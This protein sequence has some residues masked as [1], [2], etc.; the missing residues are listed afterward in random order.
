[1]ISCPLCVL[2]Q[3]AIFW[4]HT[5]ESENAFAEVARIQKLN[6]SSD[7]DIDQE[8]KACIELEPALKN[9]ET[10]WK[11]KARIKWHCEG[12]RCS[13]YFHQVTKLRHV[14]KGIKALKHDDT[15]LTNRDQ[16]EQK[17]IAYFTYHYSV[18]NN[19]TSNSLVQDRI[20][21]LVTAKD[22]SFLTTI[23]S[24]EEI[25]LV[26]FSSNADNAPGPNGF[27]CCFL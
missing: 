6:S 4:E 21:Y 9:Q 13:T 2:T 23:P 15:I 19:Y 1:M 11:D 5:L 7:P 27:G 26:V 3:W 8:T 12:D 25:R 16:I 18:A 10:F 22:N 17:I 20:P 24:K 14:T